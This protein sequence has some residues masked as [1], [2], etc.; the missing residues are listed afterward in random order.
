MENNLETL[1][2]AVAK[3]IQAKSSG[4]IDQVTSFLKHTLHFCLVEF[5]D[6]GQIGD[7]STEENGA[8][9][10]NRNENG[11]RSEHIYQNMIL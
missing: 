7:H 2:V 10:R 1:G 11:G 3:Q 8:D 6:D 4:V 5:R 9:L